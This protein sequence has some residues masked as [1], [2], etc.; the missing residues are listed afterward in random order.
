MTDSEVAGVVQWWTVHARPL[1]WRATRDVYAVWVS[2]VMSAQTTIGR[3]AAAWSRW[4]ERWPTVDALASASLAEVLAQWQGLGYPRRARDLHRS[5]RIV[6]AGGW[7]DDLQ[8]LPGVGPYIAAAVRC[9]AREEPVLPMDVNVARVLRRRFPGGV[10]IAAD[11][12]RAGQAL[13][14]FG[15]RI[16]TARPRCGECPV[17]SGCAGRGDAERG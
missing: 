14:E 13:M 15:Q 7:P 11:P 17:R 1:P 9:F 4:M 12:W 8:E 5:A 3:A 16:C 10:D 2:E 6:A